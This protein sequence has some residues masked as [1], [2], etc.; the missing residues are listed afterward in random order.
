MR[1]CQFLV[2]INGAVG[3]SLHKCFSL[4][5][6]SFPWGRA[7]KTKGWVQGWEW[8]PGASYPVGLLFGGKNHWSCEVKIEVYRIYWASLCPGLPRTEKTGPSCVWRQ[9]AKDFWVPSQPCPQLPEWTWTRPFLLSEPQCSHLRNERAEQAIVA[10][11]RLVAPIPWLSLGMLGRSGV[12]RQQCLF[13]VLIRSWDSCKCSWLR[14]WLP[15]A[16]GQDPHKAKP[17]VLRGEGREQWKNGAS[18]DAAGRWDTHSPSRLRGGEGAAT[19]F[20]RSKRKAAPLCKPMAWQGL[21]RAS[22]W[23]SLPCWIFITHADF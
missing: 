12:A 2:I 19:G 14:L 6:G 5:P 22:P 17:A 23:G 20:W 13:V 21:P 15:G 16:A 3:T 11:E 8:S 1:C 10:R 7:P 18:R 9:V 4:S